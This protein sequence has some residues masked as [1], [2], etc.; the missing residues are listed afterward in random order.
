MGGTACTEPQCLYKGALYLIFYDSILN[1]YLILNPPPQS[2]VSLYLSHTHTHLTVH[3]Y[4]CV[5]VYTICMYIG[6]Y[7][8]AANSIV[9]ASP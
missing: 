1:M 2:L 5:Y 4:V 8:H 3:A 9:D 6:L 7:I